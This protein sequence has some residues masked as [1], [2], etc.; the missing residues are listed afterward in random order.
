MTDTTGRTVVGA[1]GSAAS[2]DAVRR[3]AEQA[4]L[5]DGALEVL[6]GWHSPSPHAVWAGDEIDGDA[7]ARALLEDTLTVV[8][9]EKDIEVTRT[10]RPGHP[11]AVLTDA[12]STADLLVVGSRGHDGFAGMVLGSV[13]THVAAHARCPVV[14]VHPMH[15]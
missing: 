10:A 8:H 4:P 12:S 13:S 11:A 5:A 9:I 7:R 14:V 15:R 3:A 6:T 2:V 1:D